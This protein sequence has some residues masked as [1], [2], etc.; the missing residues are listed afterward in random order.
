[1]LEGGNMK[2]AERS[3]MRDAGK[4]GNQAPI[5]I[6]EAPNNKAKFPAKHYQSDPET[7]RQRQ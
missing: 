1:M 7:Q 3:L 6:K 2:T 5:G 4:L